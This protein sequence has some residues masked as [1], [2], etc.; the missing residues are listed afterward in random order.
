MPSKC[1]TLLYAAAWIFLPIFA[2]SKAAQTASVLKDCCVQGHNHSK[3]ESSDCGDFPVPIPAVSQED[4]N[5][6]IATMKICCISAKREAACEKG[7]KRAKEGLACRPSPTETSSSSRCQ[8]EPTMTECCI[9]CKM[10]SMTDPG[11]CGKL[12][13]LLPSQ[14]SQNSFI[15][16]CFG[17]AEDSLNDIQETQDNRCPRGFVFNEA[18]QV[19]DDIDECFEGTDSCDQNFETCQNTLGDYTC[20]P[21]IQNDDVGNWTENCPKGFKFYLISCIDIDECAENLHNCSNNQVGS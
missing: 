10:G 7:Q 8:F 9:G 5:L 21:I 20:D 17:D 14:Y 15:K 13:N 11:D 6:C 18:L 1:F 16:C 12:V 3:I 19:C 2:S 4:H